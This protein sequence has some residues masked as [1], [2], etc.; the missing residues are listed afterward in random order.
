MAA[1]EA[2]QWRA[3]RADVILGWGVLVFGLLCGAIAGLADTDG[4]TQAVST[5]LIG[6]VG[7]GILT[8]D[9]VARRK[10]DDGVDRAL[11]GIV[12]GAMSLGALIG[13]GAGIGVRLAVW[14]TEPEPVVP[15]GA[16]VDDTEVPADAGSA[17]EAADA[18]VA[19]DGR[20]DPAPEPS[21]SG[22][23]AI[24]RL[25]GL[26]HSDPEASAA[27][28]GARAVVSGGDAEPG[29]CE[30]ALA[31]LRLRVQRVHP[32]APLP[33]EALSCPARLA[34]LWWVTCSP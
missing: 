6:I 20:P 31:A 10:K 16:I 22:S 11:V 25:P 19:D 17:D 13:I 14:R 1:R 21:S 33:P 24:A 18:S 32:S 8:G 9:L 7:A 28:E 12:L 30:D 26:L 2:D 3:T 4:T 29:H 34:A 15:R 5:A 23:T 27:C